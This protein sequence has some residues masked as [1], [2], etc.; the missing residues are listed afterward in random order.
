MLQDLSVTCCIVSKRVGS[1]LH[2]GSIVQGDVVCIV[3]PAVGVMVMWF[4]RVYVKAC[5]CT[6]MGDVRWRCEVCPWS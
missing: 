2:H 3:T 1:I 6:G 4:V 5:V